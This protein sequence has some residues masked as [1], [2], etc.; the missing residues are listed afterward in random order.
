MTASALDLRR[1]LDAKP[2]VWILGLLCAAAAA[3]VLLLAAHASL[4]DPIAAALEAPG[5]TLAIAA[6]KASAAGTSALTAPAPKNGPGKRA[7]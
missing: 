6:Q 7:G 5:K 4:K 3:V 1:A 2:V